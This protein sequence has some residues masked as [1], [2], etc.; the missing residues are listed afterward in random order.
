MAS[1]FDPISVGAIEAPNRIFMA[2]VTRGRSTR[3]HV[4]TPIKVGYYVKRANRR[5]YHHRGNRHHPT[6]RPHA[7]WTERSA[8]SVPS[9]DRK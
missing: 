6:L 5:P 2:P 1:L 7:P 8:F 4:P 3:D 9:M